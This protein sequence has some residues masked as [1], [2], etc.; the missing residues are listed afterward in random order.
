MILVVGGSGTL[1]RV[2]THN[3]LVAGETVRVMTRTPAKA[4]SLRDAGAEVV[5]GDL[6]DRE[7]LV[8]ACAG[9]E[10]VIAAAHSFLGRGR[11]ASGHVDRTGHKQLIDIAK[12]SGVR[13]FVYTSA[14]INDPVFLTIP[15][16]RIKQEVEKHLRDSG[17]SYTILRPSAFMDFHAHVLI[18]IPVIQGKKVIL[19]GAG[20]R[21]R[22]FVAASDVAQLA[23]RALRDSSMANE[24][25]DIGGPENLSNVDVVR[26][27]ERIAGRKARVAHLPASV[28]TALAR[29]VRPFHHGVGQMLQMAAIADMGEQRFDAR[30]LQERFAIRL[31]R[32]EDWA[33]R[34]NVQQH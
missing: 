24:T 20:E 13:H 4:T 28:P 27:Y 1:G 30:S 2:I 10:K 22:N 25:I 18:G 15:F 9:A 7:S 14:Y 12:V 5:T 6:T 11:L 19:F 17:L 26:I 29:M 32:L 31:D 34:Q 33:R 3:L 8:R 21:P 16:M 23:V